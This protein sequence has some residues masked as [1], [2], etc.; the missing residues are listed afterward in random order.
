MR[1]HNTVFHDL[2]N[3]VP[4]PAFDKLV[5][6]HGSDHRVRRL[7][8]KSQF[9][10]LLFG[11]IAGADSL[12]AIEA[13]M[14]SQSA[15]LYHLGASAPA[16][17]TL[18]DANAR[19]PAALYQD[20][21]AHM[22]AA[23]GRRARRHMRDVIRILDATRIPLPGPMEDWK[24][25]ACRSP[26][27]KLHMAYDPAAAAPLEA[28]AT[29]SLVNDITPAKTLEIETDATYV[30][31]LGYYS[32]DWWADIHARR[33]RF[34]T[35]LKSHT[36]LRQVEERTPPE[37][38]IAERI[39]RLPRP[40]GDPM[41][42][43]VREIVV[44]IPTGKTIRLVTNDLDSPAEEIAALYKQ[45]WAVELFFRW[46][47]QNLKIRRFL[48][49]SRNAVVTQLF[50]ALIAY[51]LLRLA[52]E[53]QS[54][55]ARPSAFMRVVAQNLWQRRSINAL[56]RPPPPPERDHRQPELELIPT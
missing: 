55:I 41:P 23:A 9:I 24:A 25:G 30:F 22:A 35:R 26:A 10:A 33:A 43:R 31:D 7:D 56:N 47:K 53:A 4:W 32:F 8:S 39:G 18:A 38:V 27:V 5:E 29:S 46:I 28:A 15:R 50:V 16:R 20:L 14:A 45:R 37:G 52:H 11:Q 21:F 49:V 51:L 54:V 12:R 1:H 2:I 19:R 44:R 17:S 13:G 36:R 48:G 40:H 34:V 3:H 42:D 6:Q